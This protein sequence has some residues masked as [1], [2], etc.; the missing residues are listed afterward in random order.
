MLISSRK[1]YDVVVIGSGVAALSF[2]KYFNRLNC[3]NKCRPSLAIICKSQLT[4]TNTAWAQGGIA[5]VSNKDDNFE[6]HVQD[7]LIAGNFENN[8]CIVEKVIKEAPALIKDLVDAGMLF[9]Q[10]DDLS[11]NL[12]LEGGHSHKRIFHHKDITGQKLQDTLLKETAQQVDVYENQF[13]FDV[14][15]DDFSSFHTF[16]LDKFNKCSEIVSSYVVIATGGLGMLYEKTTN[17]P[18]TTGDGIYLGYNLGATIKDLSYVQFHPTGL[19]TKTDNCPL[20]T[21]ALRGEGAILLNIYGEPFMHKYDERKELAPRDIVSRGIFSEMQITNSNYAYLDATKLDNSIWENHFPFIY[22]TSLNNNIDPKS[23]PIPVVPTQ[24]Y[25]CGGILS[26]EFG[27]TTVKNLYAIGEVASTG[28]HGSNRLA[29]NS[30]LEGLAF[31]KFAAENIYDSFIGNW[32]Y[33]TSLIYQSNDFKLLD[34]KLLR[35]S[36]SKFAGVIKSN[37]EMINLK[38]SLYNMIK[39]ADII[40]QPN[41][42]VIENNIMYQVGLLL[43]EDAISKDYNSGVFYKI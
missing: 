30:L 19:Y 16:M 39:T 41:K 25:S 7:T 3:K 38:I 2:I 40:R 29:S 13:V 42:N 6:Y 35:K 14:K 8:S 20:I 22:K 5:A 34:R 12:A 18:L 36:I 33:S 1:K 23:N 17:Q 43:L 11:Y 31:G 9:D 37:Q 27:K 26:D 28:L 32:N 24:H 10:I 4:E 15:Q 21:E